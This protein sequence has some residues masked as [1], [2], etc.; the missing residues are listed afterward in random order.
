[1]LALEKHDHDTPRLR[2]FPLSSE[3]HSENS[4]ILPMKPGVQYAWMI[5]PTTIPF[6]PCTLAHIFSILIAFSN[7]SKHHVL[8]RIVEQGCSCEPRLKHMRPVPAKLRSYRQLVQVWRSK[9][10]HR[11]CSRRSTSSI[12]RR[13][14]PL[15][16]RVYFQRLQSR[17]KSPTRHLQ[18]EQLSIY[19]PASRQSRPGWILVSS[20]RILIRIHKTRAVVGSL[21]V[22]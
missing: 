16:L 11:L 10:R 12:M 18:Q 4:P 6:L 15:P 1:V 22:I 14:R 3:G 21:N 17:L 9:W 20:P 13:R 8:V 19:P 7:G 5:T 2:S